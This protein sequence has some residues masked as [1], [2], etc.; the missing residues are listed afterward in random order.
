MPNILDRI[1]AIFSSSQEQENKPKP[2]QEPAKQ[3]PPVMMS[4]R[5]KLGNYS[6]K[7]NQENAKKMIADIENEKGNKPKL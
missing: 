2:N 4:G 3:A 5:R 1:K 7:E 6:L